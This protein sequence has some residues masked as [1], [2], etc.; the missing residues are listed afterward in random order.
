MASIGGSS[1]S[2][3]CSG[4]TIPGAPAQIFCALVSLLSYRGEHLA[5]ADLILLDYR[6]KRQ[7]SRMDKSPLRAVPLPFWL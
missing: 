5:H 4:T 3:Q 6:T 2:D 1:N 7:T